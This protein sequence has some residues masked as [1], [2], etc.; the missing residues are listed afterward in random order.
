[1]LLVDTLLTFS[2]FFSTASGGHLPRP[3]QS[4]L[5]TNS[6]PETLIIPTGFGKTAAV[7]SSWL[8]KRA[9]GDVDT[10][11]RLVYCL[12]MRTLVEQTARVADEWVSAAREHLS[13][14][15][16]TGVLMGG[17]DEGPFNIP[18]W[19]MSPE[20]PT[21]LIGTQDMLVSAALMRG[22]GTTRYRWPVDFALLHNDAMW[23]FD[24]VQLAGSSV[25]TSAQL[26]GFRRQLNVGVP[27]RT[28]WMSA[29]LD[30]AWLDTVDFQPRDVARPHDL[31]N[32][33]LDQAGEL[34]H[35]A[36]SL[37]E[38]ELTAAAANSRDGSRR[39]A[40]ELAE[41][42]RQ[43]AVP[44]QNVI[45]FLNTVRRAQEVYRVLKKGA[46]AGDPDVT[47]IHSRFRAGDRSEATK[48]VLSTPPD[49]GRII[50]T[51]QALEAG[52]DVSSALMVT[53]I[54]PWSSLVQRFGRCNRYGERNDM[55]AQ[56]LWVNV[57]ETE[58]APY[59]NDDLQDARDIL[60]NL[61]ECG[62][63][64]LSSI[65]IPSLRPTSVIRRRDLLDLFD[66]EPDLSGFDIDVSPYVRDADDTDMTLFWRSVPENERPD[67]A[68][69]APGREELCPVPI[70]GAKELLGRKGGVRAWRWDTLSESWTGLNPQDVFPGLTIWVESGS[71]GYVK[72]W[73][74]DADSKELVPQA[75]PS[76][77][78]EQAMGRD[79]E[80]FGQKIEVTLVN[81]TAHVRHHAARL[82]GDLGLD[83][84]E[85]DLLTEVAVWH[86][87]GKAMPAFG[88]P[89]VPGKPPLAKWTGGNSKDR[90]KYFRH[91][92]AS[93]LGY[94]ERHDWAEAAS[95]TAYL[96]AAH[97]G[98]VRTRIC[99]LPK[100]QR[101]DQPDRAYARG[102][103]DGDVIQPTDLGGLVVPETILHL[104][105]MALGDSRYGPSWQARSLQLLSEHGPFRLAWLEALIRIADW[106]ASAEEQKVDPGDL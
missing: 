17:L 83:M 51:T 49:R 56:V 6:W 102:V 9:T 76:E 96:I 61:A 71:G 85:R 64:A 75:E 89:Q 65:P 38:L 2:E 78:A 22:Y 84:D 32:A 80:S 93:A 87:L 73:G 100:E 11:R 13:L 72:E 60:N 29:T 1:M 92:L 94:L 18:P 46:S 5:G 36:K 62:P 27:S 7:L 30:P 82:A 43:R 59:E 8:W 69:D 63:A 103:W 3:Y 10:P 53:E 54:A 25:P 57:Q 16:Q 55:G 70:S 66:T 40:Q 95:V 14:E 37:E 19:I 44:A 15:V 23:V 97:H 105:V 90:R 79:P 99:T 4:A 88:A 39:Y 58:A 42:V 101:P 52:V 34:W 20:V 45:V 98:K 81:H 68:R 12:P 21:I 67:A 31:S 86:D 48:A 91:E 50:V 26:E 28:M 74:F 33:D 104:D 106:N 47:L 24:E 77:A 41:E 35:A